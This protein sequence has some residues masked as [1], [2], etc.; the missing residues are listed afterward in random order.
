VVWKLDRLGRSLRHLLDV[1]ADLE[2]LGVGFKSLRESIDTTTP[3]G[4][5]V[6]HLFGALAEFERYA[7][8]GITLVMPRARLCRPGAAWRG[9]ETSRGQRKDFGASA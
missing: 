8:V 4:R 2:R 5:L 1:V 3:G 6:L 7:D 9:G